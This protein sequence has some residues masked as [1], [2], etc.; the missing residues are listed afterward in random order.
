MAQDQSYGGFWVRVVALTLDNA[1]VFIIMFAALLGMAA[2]F[3]TVGMEGLI[4]WIANLVVIFLPFLYWPVLESSGW[5]ATVGKRVM[6]LQV[7]DADGG[8]LS[9]MHRA[10]ARARQD[11]LRPFRSASA[12]WS[13]RSRRASR[14]CT[15]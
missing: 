9:F 8:R 7:T 4:A 2:V 10:D 3:T 12:S 6:G 1:I 14:R 13:R 15:T 11:R 5:Q